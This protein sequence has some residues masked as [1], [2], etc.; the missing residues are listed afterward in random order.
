V[1][2]GS[3]A[4]YSTGISF[5]SHVGYS[6]F[7]SVDTRFVRD[8]LLVSVV[9]SATSIFAGF[10]VFAILGHLAHV[11]GVSVAELQLGGPGLAFMAY[12]TAIALV[13][14]GNVLAVLFFVMLSFVGLDSMMGMMEVVLTSLCELRFG[15]FDPAHRQTATAVTCTIG[16]VCGL[17]CATRG[18]VAV[19]DV[20]D[21]FC[22]IPAGFLI[23]AGEAGTIAYIYG[24]D[25]FA[26]LVETEA[27]FRVPRW[28]LFIWR[29]LSTP[30]ATL[31]CAASLYQAA[32]PN[33]LGEGV[34]S[35]AYAAGWTMGLACIPVLA[36]CGW[37]GRQIRGQTPKLVGA[38]IVATPPGDEGAGKGGSKSSWMM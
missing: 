15:I 23:C 24:V 36:V 12:P 11:Q 37:Y 2:A 10:V 6:S 9:N 33:Y 28:L 7:N 13:P 31:L 4:F 19:V 26:A 38:P 35:A 5:G 32:Q 18:G 14:G 27:G 30:L 22:M 21:F 1:R 8:G 16:F 25:R 20:F 17:A 34:P 3:Q 29:Y